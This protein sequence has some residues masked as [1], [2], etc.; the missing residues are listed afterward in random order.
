[1]LLAYKQKVQVLRCNQ[2]YFYYS[3]ISTNT[4][5]CQALDVELKFY[6]LFQSYYQMEPN[7]I[8]CYKIKTS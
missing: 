3:N 2:V 4:T 7:S 6:T 5:H 1:M 8:T